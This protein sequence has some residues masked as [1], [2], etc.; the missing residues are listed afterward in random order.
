MSELGKRLRQAR[1]AAGISLSGMSSRTGYS[2]GYLGNV[3]NGVRNATLKL[4][5][6]YE[7]VLGEDV[8]RR[9][10]LA[11][12]AAGAAA[13]AIPAMSIDDGLAVDVFRDIAAERSRLLS[14]A[15]TSHATDRA[16]SSL[17][18]RDLS[19]VGSL[20]KWARRGTPVL[21]VNS[22]GILAKVGSPDLDND[23]IAA[24]KADEESRQLYLT[25]VCARV[26]RLPWDD[27]AYL[28]Q[29]NTP[30]SE[31]EWFEAF[32][33]EVCNPNDSGA[34]WCSLLLLARTRPDAPATVDA[35]LMQA[36]KAEPS[37]EILRAI[38]GTLAGIDPLTV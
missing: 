11:G 38:G 22:L 3:E 27:A 28:A 14:T 37:R 25:A 4:I 31:Q 30:L 17:V 36:L 8:N 10:L 1:E 9:S 6:A 2:D 32:T 23:V 20:S 33:T 35:A 18:A 26:A 34:R 15:Q 13:T 19:S 12:L 7:Q 5:R 21:R 24:L 29:Q 16:I